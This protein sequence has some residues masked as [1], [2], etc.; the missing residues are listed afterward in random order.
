MKNKNREQLTKI[1][2][3]NEFV[4]SIIL[5]VAAIVVL[6]FNLDSKLIIAGL[7]IYFAF[8]A[9]DSYLITQCRC[10]HCGSKDVFI[11]KMGFTMG[12]DKHCHH[13]GKRINTA[14]PIKEIVY[15]G[16]QKK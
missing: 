12:I 10:E 14:Q 11:R 4:S 3:I 5:L 1:I 7:V 13:C 16:R 8:T 9:F 2:R 6:R 15:H